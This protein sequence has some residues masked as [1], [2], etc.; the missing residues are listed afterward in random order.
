MNESFVV[1][2][3]D[4]GFEIEQERFECGVCDFT[5][6]FKSNVRRHE[7]R[8][9]TEGSDPPGVEDGRIGILCDQC[10]RPFKTKRGLKLHVH[11]KHLNIFRFKCSVCPSQFNM[12][13]AFRGHLASH[14]RELKE[15][16]AQCGAAFQYKQSLKRSYKERTPYS[17][18]ETSCLR[19]L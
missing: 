9:L 5:S 1:N 2:P 4:E 3:S 14:H 16:C 18:E 15:K 12:L 11:T 6:R 8:H 7:R 10:A 13:S 17:R 19:R